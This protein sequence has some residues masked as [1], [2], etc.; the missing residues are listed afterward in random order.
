MLAT[1][2]ISTA[3]LMAVLMTTAAHATLT[4]DQIWANWQDNAATAGLS[5]VA[6]SKITDGDV[7]TLTGVTIGP[8]VSGELDIEGSIDEITM[9]Q[10]G[11]GSVTIAFAPEFT[12]PLPFG[13]EKGTFTVTHDNMTLP[14]READGGT[15]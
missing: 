13:E 2:T 6:E 3:G 11:D 12:V 1:K 9:T 5:L 8:E 10:G 14:A 15:A 7:T 4:A